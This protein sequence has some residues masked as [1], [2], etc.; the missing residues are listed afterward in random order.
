M[1]TRRAFTLLELLV[2][3][4]LIGLLMA[5]LAAVRNNA[6]RTACASNLRQVGVA[7]RTYLNGCNDRMPYASFMPSIDAFPLDGNT[8]IRI[9]DVLVGDAGNQAKVFHCPND[10]GQ[11]ERGAPNQHRSYFDSEGSS[12]EYQTRLGGQTL[13]QFA[14]RIE[15]FT[16]R[17]V[18]VNTIWILRDY[19]NFHAAGGTP[20]ARRYLYID[21]RVTDYET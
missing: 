1:N 12:Y 15:E 11:L 3:V 18:P 21:G 5:S 9:A 10:Q 13:E 2:V 14:R 8:P 6:R 20:G 16:G 7:L 17:K 19:N 4:A